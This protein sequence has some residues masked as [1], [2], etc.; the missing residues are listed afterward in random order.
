M[1]VLLMKFRLLFFKYR[2]MHCLEPTLT[3][4]ALPYLNLFFFSFLKSLTTVLALRINPC[5]E[6]VLLNQTSQHS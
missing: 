4:K 2:L 1:K 6:F 3:I 5:F